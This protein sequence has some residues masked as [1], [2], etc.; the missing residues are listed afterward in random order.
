M[1]TFNRLDLGRYAMDEDLACPECGR[2]LRKI[3]RTGLAYWLKRRL[4]STRLYRCP[5]CQRNFW[6]AGEE[7]ES[8]YPGRPPAAIKKTA[9]EPDALTTRGYTIVIIL[10]F[11]LT[12]ILIAI[13]GK[14]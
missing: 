11:I 3:R 12:F 1:I 9:D 2:R 4:S 10:S 14:R 6:R 8:G 13:F 7:V 5:E